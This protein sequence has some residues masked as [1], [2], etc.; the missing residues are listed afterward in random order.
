MTFNSLD[1]YFGAGA[2]L[3]RPMLVHGRHQQD[4]PV[5]AEQQPAAALD[6]AAQVADIGRVRDQNRV[7]SAGA[8]G[9]PLSIA[10]SIA[11]AGE[12]SLKILKYLEV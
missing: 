6:Q 8:V 10:E 7:D 4:G 9:G 5:R 11:S 1:A 3:R 12:A 2:F